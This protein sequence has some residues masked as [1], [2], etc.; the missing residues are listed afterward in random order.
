MFGHLTQASHTADFNIVLAHTNI[1]EIKLALDLYWRN[2]VPPE[3]IN[4]GLGFYGRSFQLSDPSCYQPGCLFKGGASPGVCSD[5]SGTLTYREIMNIIDKYNLRPYYDKKS[6]VKYVTWNSDQWV[7]YDDEDTFQAKIKFSNDNGLGGLLIWALDQD[8]AQ[9]DALAGVIHPKRL[10]SIGAEAESVNHWDELG[11]GD[12]YVT[13]CGTTGCKSGE[14]KMT[15]QQCDG[16]GLLSSLCCPFAAA[17][18]PD[19]CTWRGTA[20][21]CNGRC[22][23]GEVA[24]ESNKWGDG[25]HCDDG[26]KF[27][28]CPAVNEIPDCRWTKCGGSCNSDEKELTWR[29]GN[30]FFSEQVFCCN[31]D[32]DW[33]NCAWHGKD[34]SCFDNRKCNR[35]TDRSH[36]TLRHWR[37]LANV[38][39]RLRHWTLCGS[40]DLVRRRRGQLRFPSGEGAII[41]LRCRR[42]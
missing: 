34:G 22:H 13:S 39:S 36:W 40:H 20:P 9:L 29:D 15:D 24:L 11:A 7:S 42:W 27:Y 1:T 19:T 12:C 2:S 21:Q 18:N 10:G 33:E 17:P 3:K 25:K 8:T 26:L 32:Q 28:C 5:N 31:K 23:S 38:C 41:L 6:Q 30:C 4:L 16:D 14:V 35:A 37:A